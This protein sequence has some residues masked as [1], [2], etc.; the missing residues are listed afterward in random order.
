MKLVPGVAY[1]PAMN[2][3]LAETSFQGLPRGSG[4]L[5]RPFLYRLDRQTD[6]RLLG[7]LQIVVWLEHA[8]NDGCSH[9]G[10]HGSCSRTNS[11]TAFIVLEVY[12]VA[13]TFTSESC[14]V[15]LV[16]PPKSI[17]AYSRRW[18]SL[19]VHDVPLTPRQTATGG[20]G[21]PCGGGG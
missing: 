17:F 15:L 7:Q 19:A 13:A 10:T 11:C 3:A 8:V 21:G 9:L 18:R 1:S 16:T 12:H 4:L 2:G 5:G 14:S 20:G 6:P